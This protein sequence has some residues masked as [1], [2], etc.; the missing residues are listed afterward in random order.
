MGL[1]SRIPQ[2]ALDL[3]P[4]VQYAIEA[5]GELVAEAARGRVPVLTGRLR[6]SIHVDSQDEGVYVIA[7]DNKV[8]YGML[9]EHGTRYAPAHPFLLP[10]LEENRA[11]IERLAAK[12]VKEVS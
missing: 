11:E 2:I 4:A 12:A 7:G 8:F 9:V 3:H 10:A 1:E 6:D 5:G